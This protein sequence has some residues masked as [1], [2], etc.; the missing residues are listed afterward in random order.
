MV[1]CVPFSLA[2]NLTQK[3]TELMDILSQTNGVKR[4]KASFANTKQ[5]V[6]VISEDGS[7]PLG[8]LPPDSMTKKDFEERKRRVERNMNQMLQVQE[9]RSGKKGGRFEKEP[10][11][12]DFEVRTRAEILAAQQNSS[13]KSE[14]GGSSQVYTGDVAQQPKT[15]SMESEE[16]N[17]PNNQQGSLDDEFESDSDE[18][19]YDSCPSKVEFKQ[20]LKD[21]DV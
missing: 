4:P 9:A 18:G 15:S 14:D 5:P 19:R 16:S 17:V 2:P 20:M 6:H 7:D 10:S 21:H 11:I 13:P 1:A 8:S 3:L 12:N